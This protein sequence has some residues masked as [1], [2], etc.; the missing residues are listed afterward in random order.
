MQKTK[1]SPLR[2]LW[3]SEFVT[4]AANVSYDFLRSVTPAARKIFVLELR[5][6]TSAAPER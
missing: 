5:L 6:S 4:T 2:E 3:P 1:K